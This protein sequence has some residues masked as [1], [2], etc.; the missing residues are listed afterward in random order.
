MM[1]IN[2]NRVCHSM[3]HVCFAGVGITEICQKQMVINL[4]PVL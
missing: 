3:S 1:S 2:R 4:Q